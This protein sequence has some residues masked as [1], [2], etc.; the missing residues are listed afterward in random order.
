M[1]CFFKLGFLDTWDVLVLILPTSIDSIVIPALV[2]M[3]FIFGLIH[4][5]NFNQYVFIRVAL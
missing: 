1:F 4:P 2:S 5:P 3:P